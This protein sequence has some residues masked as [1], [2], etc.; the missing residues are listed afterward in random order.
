MD[1]EQLAADFKRYYSH[2]LG[3]DENCTSPHYAYEALSMAI[4]DRLM[5][6]WKRTYNAY[7]EQDCKRAILFV[8]GI[9]NGPYT[10][11]MPC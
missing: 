9:F 10:S 2:R 6:R 3:R 11:V 5:E 1:K 8:D 7:K 4:S